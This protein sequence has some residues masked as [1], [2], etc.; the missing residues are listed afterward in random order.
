MYLTIIFMKRYY[1]AVFHTI[2]THF[3]WGHFR[4]LMHVVLSFL[5]LLAILTN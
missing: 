3:G 5:G 2:V 1:P 4:A